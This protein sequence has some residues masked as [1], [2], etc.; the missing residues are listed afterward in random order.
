MSPGAF[1]GG[2][3]A[4]V[5]RRPWV[6][7]I[8][9]AVLAVAAI[10]S[11]AGLPSQQVTDA[12]FDHDS[13]AYSQTAK[14]NE[15]FGDDPVVVLA[16]GEL[17]ETVSAENIRRLNLLEQCLAGRAESGRGRFFKICKE[18]AD[19]DPT[20]LIAGPGSFLTQAV[21]GINRVYNQQ[22]E[23]LDSLPEGATGLDV[24]RRQQILSLA[25]EVVSRYG[26]V[27]PPTLD[28]ANFINQVV[29]GIGN[30]RNG[31]KPRLSYL[32]PN[33]QSAQI[34]VRLR[35]DLDDDQRSRAISLIK[36]AV[37]DP[38]VDLEGSDYV[39]SGSP[40][41]FE[42][43]SKALAT[44]V[45]VLA[46]IALVL[47]SIALAVVFGST[48]RLLP[49][50]MSLAAAAIM[51]GLL[52]LF[53][54]SVSLA[55]V[56]VL[57]ILIGLAVDYAVQIQARYDETDG[58][59]APGEAARIAATEGV[60]MIATACVATAFG[61]AALM[62]SSLPLVAEFGLL[63]GV[64]VLVC[65]TVVFLLGFAALSIRGPGKPGPARIRQ[66]F[67]FD[68]L[69]RA[70]ESMIALS[71]VAPRRVLVVS[72]VVAACGWA[73]STQA[74]TDADINQVLPSRAAAVED[75]TDLEDSTG[76]SGEIDLIVSADDVTD[77]EVV[78]WLAEVR[79]DILFKAGYTSTG[80]PDCLA[81]DL[82]PGP[83]I[84]DFLPNSG[85][86][87]SGAQNRK[88]LSALP[89]DELSGFIAGGLRK[90]T[91]PTVAKVPFAVRTGS[92]ARQGELIEEINSVIRTS[93]AGQGPPDGVNVEVTGL[94]VVITSAVDDLASSRFLLI[95]AGILLIALVL[96]LIYRSPWR[97]VVPILPILIAGG[98]SAMIISALGVKLNPLSA[99]LAVLVTAIA[100]EFSVIMAGRYYQ[101]R[102]TGMSIGNALRSSYGSTGMAI[103]ASGFTAIA[104]FAALGF[105]DIPI[106]RDFGLIAV[107]D[108]GVALL[109]V[110]LVL[111]A[112]LVWAEDR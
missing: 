46:I 56:G 4:A 103:A 9:G 33:D 90:G 24:V 57:P 35:S 84:P 65:L 88:A 34:V 97:V 77:P 21:D 12:F 58:A 50:G 14:A 23:R 13:A 74:E 72:L 8:V 107:L 25:A 49:L 102:A 89:A 44:S 108:L 51:L 2:L 70:V 68:W 15:K 67:F 95:G 47:M 55:A 17:L 45:L 106:L 30:S 18:I 62:L 76:L 42:G 83:S 26:L 66:V 37:D 32:F 82:C 105:S 94:P 27:S 98:W 53:G 1:F 71:V 104:G 85:I 96:A 101:Q 79:S 39:V 92:V 61:F 22:L 86:G 80:E 69:R 20:R 81:A 52:R 29:F 41:V 60:P 28:D 5:T 16:K 73:A 100:T 59:L 75:L 10:I 36:R 112:A 38:A 110:A 99:V 78:A 3:A 6:V 19:L 7:L 64:G 63:L 31:P 54:G 111:P 48:W 87:S 109:G 93:R 11:T 43:L 40:V 91:T